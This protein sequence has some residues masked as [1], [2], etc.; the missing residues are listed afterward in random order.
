MR[1]P[2]GSLGAPG[3]AEVHEH[4]ATRGRLQHGVR[5]LEVAVH[6]GR[7]LAVQVVED[8]EQ[9]E[10]HV[11]HPD[12]GQAGAAVGA[13]MFLQG[14]AH[15]QGLHQEVA[16]VFREV[17]LHLGQAGV[18]ELGQHLGFP[19]EAGQRFTLLFVGTC[20]HRHDLEGP[21][22]IKA[23]VTHAEHAAP[24]RRYPGAPGRNSV[25]GA[26]SPVSGTAGLLRRTHRTVPGQHW[27]NHTRG[28]AL[29]R[30]LPRTWVSGNFRG[31]LPGG[32]KCCLDSLSSRRRIRQMPP[33]MSLLRPAHDRTERR[34]RTMVAGE[35]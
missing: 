15:H 16:A 1:V 6:H 34:V 24:W 23:L 22:A 29:R 8:L 12:R 28:S 26:R 3:D 18:V 21:L 30:L 31:A 25:P 33:L 10:R 2:R 19:F 9:V 4:H 20:L 11:H 27:R 13:E 5:G 14:G 17:V 7:G 32:Q 35:K